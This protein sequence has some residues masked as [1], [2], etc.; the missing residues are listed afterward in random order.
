[1][2]SEKREPFGLT[3]V[4]DAITQDAFGPLTRRSGGTRLISPT[5]SRSRGLVAPSSAMSA[6]H[7]AGFA[8]TRSNRWIGG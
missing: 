8:E 2:P 4:N 1:V 5:S 3:W 6:S 7:T